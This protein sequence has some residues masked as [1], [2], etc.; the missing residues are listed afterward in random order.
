LEELEQSILQ[1]E[2]KEKVSKEVIK[3]RLSK[4]YEDV[5]GSSLPTFSKDMVED[6]SIDSKLSTQGD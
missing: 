5:A 3:D 6:A 1:R 4:K 2:D